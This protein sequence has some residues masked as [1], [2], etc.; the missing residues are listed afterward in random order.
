MR[1]IAR[2][3]LRV[4]FVAAGTLPLLALLGTP[5]QAADLTITTTYPTVQVDP[6]GQVKLP[7]ERADRHARR[8]SISRSPTCRTAGRPRSTGGGFIVTLGVTR[9]GSD[10]Q[11]GAART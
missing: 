9:H 8:W 4:L 3:L 11:P 5:V 2:R 6:G 7:L 1:H 10:G